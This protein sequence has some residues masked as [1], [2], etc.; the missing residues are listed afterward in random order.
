MLRIVERGAR[1]GVNLRD[2]DTCFNSI[3]A[4]KCSVRR[5][6]NPRKELTQMTERLGSDRTVCVERV[7]NRT[8][9]AGGRD[10]DR[11]RGRAK[12]ANESG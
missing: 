7:R 1:S 3:F 2:V 10:L 9:V 4:A 6:S 8:E 5:K 11:R 12:T